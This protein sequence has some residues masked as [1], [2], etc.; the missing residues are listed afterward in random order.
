MAADQ[1]F[2]GKSYEGP[3]GLPAFRGT[4]GLWKN[5]PPLAKR[6]VSHDDFVTEDF[7]RDDP[8]TFWYVWG[9]IFNRYKKCKPHKGYAK[10]AEIIDLASK[11]DKYFV[12]H[13]GVD[14]FYMRSG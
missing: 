8:N 1:K 7:F 2:S 12:Y 6:L 5:Y 10:L 3:D 9:D 14:K 11:R 13:S 4:H